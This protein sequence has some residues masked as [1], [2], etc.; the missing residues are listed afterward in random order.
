MPNRSPAPP[1]KL[2]MAV[3]MLVWIP[4]PREAIGL[5]L[6]LLINVV[7]TLLVGPGPS[8]MKSSGCTR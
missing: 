3:R 2:Q 5:S 8:L 4:P 6:S 7:R 1:E